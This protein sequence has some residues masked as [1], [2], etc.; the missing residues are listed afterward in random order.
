L[1]ATPKKDSR[2]LYG[3]LAWT[4]PIISPVEDY[5]EEGELLARIIEEESHIPAQTLLNLGCGGGHVDFYLKRHYQITAADI[6]QP[7]L[8]LARK[9]NPEITYLLGDMRGLRLGRE[10]DAVLI[11]D[12]INYMLT[13]DDLRA[14]FQTACQHLRRGGVFIT[15]VEVWPGS[16]HQNKTTVT[17]RQKGGVEIVFI[18]NYCFVK[19]ISNSSIMAV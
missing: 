3:D 4:W 5:R 8:E 6:S 2:R 1:R 16:F 9:L 18:E 13:P 12:A 17:S 15:M 11:H 14:A 10:F 7:M 19:L